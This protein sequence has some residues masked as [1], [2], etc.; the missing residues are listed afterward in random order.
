VIEYV[1][2]VEV[3]LFWFAGVAV[4]F[5]LGMLFEAWKRRKLLDEL[6]TE[7][8]GAHDR[9]DYLEARQPKHDARGRFT[10]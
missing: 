2:V 8:A 4:I 5:V 6:E 7:L 9:I 10:R 1:E 3:L